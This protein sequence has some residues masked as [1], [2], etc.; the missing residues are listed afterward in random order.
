MQQ[1]LQDGL[2]GLAGVDAIG[3]E[4]SLGNGQ[5]AK[6]VVVLNTETMR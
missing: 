5:S 1:G 4:M 2:E 6:L 3:L